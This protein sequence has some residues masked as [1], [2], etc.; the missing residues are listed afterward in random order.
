[1]KL[2]KN[3]SWYILRGRNKWLICRLHCRIIYLYSYWETSRDRQGEAQLPEQKYHGSHDVFLHDIDKQVKLPSMLS[4]DA[5]Q[6]LLLKTLKLE[7]IS[8][9]DTFV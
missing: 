2:L 9:T 7:F 1:M 6:K 3:S 5:M 4:M 8:S